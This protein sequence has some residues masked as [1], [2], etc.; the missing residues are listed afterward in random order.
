M[1]ENLFS[2][3]EAQLILCKGKT[4]FLH[5][6]CKQYQKVYKK[7]PVPDKGNGLLQLNLPATFYLNINKRLLIGEQN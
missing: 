7:K 1:Q 4:F 2:I 6:S 3:A 5:P